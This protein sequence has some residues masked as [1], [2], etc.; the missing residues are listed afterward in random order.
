MKKNNMNCS[1]DT[2]LE[3]YRK[4]LDI[5]ISGMNEAELNCSISH[6]FIVQMIPHHKAAIEM[7][8]NIL[9]YTENKELKN[10]A[11]NIISEQ[12][13]SIKNMQKIECTCNKL[14]NTCQQV[15][16]YQRNVDQILK[17]MFSEMGNAYSDN[18]LNCDFMR[19]MIP[20]HEGAVKMSKNALRFR[21]CSEL[22]PILEN[23]IKSQEKGICEMKNLLTSLNC[24]N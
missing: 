20:H 3:E 13:E 7:S 18:R 9:K 6:N 16:L 11:E 2:Y 1:V 22:K 17:V 10:I 14:I 15:R 19:E 24:R 8:E 5:M 12:T 4:I 21:I 23:I